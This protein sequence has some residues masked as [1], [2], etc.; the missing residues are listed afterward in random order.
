MARFERLPY[1]PTT[2]T[3]I[4]LNCMWAC[5]VKASNARRRQPMLPASPLN[6]SRP[7]ACSSN[8]SAAVIRCIVTLINSHE[9]FHMERPAPVSWKP[10]SNTPELLQR[11]E[12]VPTCAVGNY[13]SS[14][15]TASL[16]PPFSRRR[17][18]ANSNLLEF[19]RSPPLARR[20]LHKMSASLAA[21]RRRRCTT[22]IDGI[23]TKCKH[24]MTCFKVT[25][26]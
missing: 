21:F 14:A 6:C 16:R 3:C 5:V 23:W 9:L 12:S 1:S 18:P 20:T 17:H 2:P 22:F 10:A 25:C 8:D 7:R 4:Q 15:A 11:N 19:T 13:H 24:F 26:I